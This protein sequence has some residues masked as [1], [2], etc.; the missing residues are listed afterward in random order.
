MAEAQLII[1]TWLITLITHCVR[2]NSMTTTKSLVVTVHTFHYPQNSTEDIL[3]TAI[4]ANSGLDTQR[5]SST[6]LNSMFTV[7]SK[8]LD[9]FRFLLFSSLNAQQP[10]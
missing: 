1:N 6:I 4:I 8:Y 7:H 2:A 9:E 3:H 10:A 5:K